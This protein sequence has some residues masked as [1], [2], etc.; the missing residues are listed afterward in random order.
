[1]PGGDRGAET[2]PSS[3]G[4]PGGEPEPAHP[5]Q[6]WLGAVSDPLPLA[7]RASRRVP[8][9]VLWELAHRG[10]M[11]WCRCAPYHPAHKAGTV[12]CRSIG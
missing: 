5:Q 4:F 7:C 6:Q 2:S 9:V 3:P 10:K 11:H 8:H 1:M 12:L